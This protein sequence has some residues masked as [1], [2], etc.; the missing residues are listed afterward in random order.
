[1]FFS[2]QEKSIDSISDGHHRLE[3]VCER[4]LSFESAPSIR[5]I[6]TILK[7]GQDKLLPAVTKNET[8]TTS[9]GITRGAAYYL[10]GGD[11]S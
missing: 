3:A 10:K 11:H 8:T 4:V 2:L 6:I 7:N 1:M 5:T 9:H